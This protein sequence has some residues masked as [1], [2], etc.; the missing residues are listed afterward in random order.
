MI[1]FFSKLYDALLEKIQGYPAN[2]YVKSSRHSELIFPRMYR[3]RRSILPLPNVLMLAL[4]NIKK[5]E[6]FRDVTPADYDDLLLLKRYLSLLK[7]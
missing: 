2:N 5:K 3:V 7:K 1:F 4:K 6:S